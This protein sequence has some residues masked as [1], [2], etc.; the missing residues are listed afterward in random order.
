MNLEELFE[1][2]F[3]GEPLRTETVDTT[4]ITDGSFLW[5]IDTCNT[6]DMGFETAIKVKYKDKTVIDWTIVE[7]YSDIIAAEMGHRVWCID[8][9][10][11]HPTYFYDVRLKII[12]GAEVKE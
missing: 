7:E 12:C 4:Y 1:E 8:V 6:A 3:G 11:N 2:I 9:E 10:R 5:I